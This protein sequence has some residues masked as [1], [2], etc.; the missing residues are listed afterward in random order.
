MARK[1]FSVDIDCDGETQTFFYRK[2]SGRMMLKQSD[3]YKANALSNEQSG[4]DLLAE[5]I[6]NEDGSPVGKDRVEEILA[7]DW[8]VM[9]KLQAVLLPKQEEGKNA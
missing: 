4:V 1:V 9:Q 8:D 5:C 6:C 7:M 2:P 3:K